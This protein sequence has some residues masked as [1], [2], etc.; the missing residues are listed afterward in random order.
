MNTRTHAV[1]VHEIRRLDAV[2]LGDMPKGHREELLRQ[3]AELK[4]LLIDD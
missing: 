1:V 3:R 2:L 4:E